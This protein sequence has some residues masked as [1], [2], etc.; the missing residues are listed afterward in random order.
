MISLYISLKLPT[1]E[2]SKSLKSPS[3]WTRADLQRWRKSGCSCRTKSFESCLKVIREPFC[4]QLLGVRLSYQ[5][6]KFISHASY[7]HQSLA[8][9]LWWRIAGNQRIGAGVGWWMITK[10][11]MMHWHDCGLY[12]DI[13]LLE[14]AKKKDLLMAFVELERAFDRVF[15]E[16]VWWALRYLNVM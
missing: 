6:H 2:T 5:N 9:M 15:P 14:Y 7:S 3:L 11:R 4:T 1:A 10:V 8:V 12:R 16:L 13:M